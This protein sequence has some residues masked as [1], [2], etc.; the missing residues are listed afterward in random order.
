MSVT[1]ENVLSLAADVAG[2]ALPLI[3]GGGLMVRAASHADD[4]VDAARATNRI[5]SLSDE[6]ITTG[7]NL[8]KG[9]G[10][11]LHHFATNKSAK[12]PPQIKPKTSPPV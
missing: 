3:T 1:L 10:D 4:A 11:Q 2:L 9:L 6:A 7:N 5:V 12:K 8:I